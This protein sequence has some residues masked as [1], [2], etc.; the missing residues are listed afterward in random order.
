MKKGE[1]NKKKITWDISIRW[2]FYIDSEI[3]V[4]I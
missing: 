3:L 2:T 4:N 1:E